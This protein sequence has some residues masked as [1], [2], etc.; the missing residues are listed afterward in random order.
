M[1]R[2]A[3]KS[4]FVFGS[5]LLAAALLDSNV[6][7]S[8]PAG[9]SLAQRVARLEHQ[10]NALEQRVSSLEATSFKKSGS[11][12]TL[13]VN[14][15]RV[16]I[17]PRGGVTVHAATR[18]R[19]EAGATTLPIGQASFNFGPGSTTT[20]SAPPPANPCDP[21]YSIDSNGIRHVLPEC[22]K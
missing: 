3:H 14:G 20:L 7:R 9:G 5:L 10:V 2:S 18:L 17:D 1:V 8:Q 21:P 19:L 11:S 12:Y 6:G 22:L 4:W 16:D 15:A 13:A